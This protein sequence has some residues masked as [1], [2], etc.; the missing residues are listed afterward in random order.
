MH[1]TLLI[2]GSH[3]IISAL[4]DQRTSRSNPVTEPQPVIVHVDECDFDDRYGSAVWTF[5][6]IRKRPT[7]DA[8]AAVVTRPTNSGRRRSIAIPER[9]DQFF[10]PP[11]DEAG[12]QA[13]NSLPDAG[14]RPTL[15]RRAT[16]SP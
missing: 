15:P 13:P 11:S 10:R 16:R 2:R 8:L 6:L 5:A 9:R 3:A 14:L 7:L 1:K 4:V 12:G